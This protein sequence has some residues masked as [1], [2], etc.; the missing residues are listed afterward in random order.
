MGAF[1]EFRFTWAGTERVIPSDKVMSAIARVEEHVTLPELS[2]MA[3]GRGP[4]MMALS[5]ALWELLNMTGQPVPL[6]EVY[7]GLFTDNKTAQ[8]VS[9]LATVLIM[10]MVP[11]ST[12]EQW[13]KDF[14]AR[15]EQ[16][17]SEVEATLRGNGNRRA[18][19][20]AASSSKQ[21]SKRRTNGD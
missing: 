20:A 19:R 16:I 9:A 11:E 2:Q 21:R 17:T 12:K 6:D 14:E 8:Q 5:Q 4:K 15:N 3:Q 18:R 7:A 10:L 13:K 1:K